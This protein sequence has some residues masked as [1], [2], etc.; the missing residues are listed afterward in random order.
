MSARHSWPR[1]SRAK[2]EQDAEAT[3]MK[4]KLYNPGNVPS[5]TEAL[6]R[7]RVQIECTANKMARLA[8]LC[9]EHKLISQA[10]QL[11][12]MLIYV[13]RIADTIGMHADAAK[14]KTGPKPKGAAPVRGG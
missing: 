14:Q 3:H 6:R 10:E 11:R 5:R 2:H 9:A 1:A 8:A 12:H 4:R 13:A 7:L